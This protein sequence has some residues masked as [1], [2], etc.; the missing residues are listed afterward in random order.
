M[1][2]SEEVDVIYRSR[3]TLLDQ[4]ESDGYNTDPYRKFSPKEIY[5]MIKGG[6]DDVLKTAPALRMDLENPETKKKCVVIYTINKIK[7]KLNSF[8]LSLV[9]DDNTFNIDTKNSEVII[10]TLEPIAPNFHA[11]AFTVWTKFNVKLRYFQA[12]SLVNNPMKHILVP[13]HEIVP[14]DEEEPLLKSMFAKKS[15]LPIIRFH[16]DP[17]A[18]ILGAVPGDIVKITRPSPTAGECVVY[19]I[20]IP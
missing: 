4:L 1:S 11:M 14:K 7:Q 8:T 13:K 20:C 19:R 15:E 10:I 3:T 12:A 17:I 18:R 2:S 6:K 5:E 16:E 9:G